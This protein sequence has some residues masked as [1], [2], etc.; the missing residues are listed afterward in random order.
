M[1][2]NVQERDLWIPGMYGLYCEVRRRARQFAGSD[3]FNNFILICVII[4]TIILA[5]DGLVTDDA[6][7]NAFDDLNMAFTI[8]F[9]VEMALKIFGFGIIRNTFTIFLK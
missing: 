2:L 6:T 9:I 3:L 5:S 7:S 1:A 4:N 8:V